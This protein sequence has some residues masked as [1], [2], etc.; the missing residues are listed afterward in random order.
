VFSEPV[1]VLFKSVTSSLSHSYNGWVGRIF[2]YICK[3]TSKFSFYT[4][5]PI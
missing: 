3:T 5:K 4:L 2:L 1:D